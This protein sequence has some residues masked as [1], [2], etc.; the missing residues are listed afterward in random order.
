MRGVK[1]SSQ[2]VLR[3]CHMQLRVCMYVNIG[4][5][6]VPCCASMYVLESV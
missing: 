1:T 5:C 2:I 3:T 6:F 4:L